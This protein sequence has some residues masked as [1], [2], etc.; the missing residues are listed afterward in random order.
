MATYAPEFSQAG[1][2]CTSSGRRILLVDADAFF[3]AVARQVD[4]DGAGKTPLLIVGGNPGSRGVVCS[5]SYECRAYGVRSAMP[6]SKALRLCPDAL[7]VP[8][9]REACLTRSRQIQQVLTQFAPVVQPSS[10]DEWYCDLSGTEALYRNE[11]IT[12]TAHRIRS[13]VFEHTGLRVSIGSGTS[14]LIAKLAVESAKPSA[15]P[16]AQGVFNVPEGLEKAFLRRF[17]LSDLPMVGPRMSARLADLGLSTVEQA[18]LWTEAQFVRQLGERAGRWLFHRV[19]GIDG[20]P[21]TPRDVQKQISRET[22]F[23]SDQQDGEA[24]RRELMRLAI[25]ASFDLRRQALRARTITVKLRN[26]NF[27]TR[28]LQCTLPQGVESEHSIARTARL[29]YERL[30]QREKSAI[31]LIGVALSHFADDEASQ[32][33]LFSAHSEPL[34]SPGTGHLG[35]SGGVER[36]G[37]SGTVNPQ[38]PSETPRERALSHA[39]DRI[40]NRFGSNAILRAQFSGFDS[41]TGPRVEE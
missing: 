31:R 18:Q 13:A 40:R 6:I 4:P 20:T 2:E 22:T 37:A 38:Y 8:V 41:T 7:S 35:G 39:M 19:N 21:V 23:A 5:A 12:H 16:G 14:R 25:R 15:G 10:I 29:L 26:A 27:K 36:S 30:R 34:E 9:P 24:I 11:P 3:V 17:R 32:L 33:T 1:S 28:T